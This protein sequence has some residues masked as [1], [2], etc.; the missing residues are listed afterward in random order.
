M[1]N[2]ANFALASVLAWGPE[3]RIARLRFV[4]AGSGTSETPTEEYGILSVT[5]NSAGNWTVALRDKKL[6]DI[7]VI[8]S[9]VENDTTL[10]RTV[11][12]ESYDLTNGT[13]V[14]T[15]KS[16]AWASITSGVTASDTVDQI[17]LLVAY[18]VYA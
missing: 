1:S 5:R 16:V 13:F 15:H 3:L 2:S 17:A 9:Y 8:P 18:R 6:K 11:R 14:L 4:P 10:H 7:E 12:A